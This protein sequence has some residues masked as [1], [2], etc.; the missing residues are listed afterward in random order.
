MDILSQKTLTLLRDE[1]VRRT[2]DE[3]I[4]QPKTDS[5]TVE[6]VT[7]DERGAGE[8]RPVIRVRIQRIA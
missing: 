3:L 7:A 6:L 8:V 5:Q 4:D 1:N 2:I